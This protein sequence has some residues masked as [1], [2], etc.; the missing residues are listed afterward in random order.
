VKMKRERRR[1]ENKLS[2]N[3]QHTPV[4]SSPPPTHTHI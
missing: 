3:P 1:R 4:L 2:A